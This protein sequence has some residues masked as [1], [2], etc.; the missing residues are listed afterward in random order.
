MG[1]PL[2]GRYAS[3]KLGS[4]LVANGRRWT[5]DIRLDEIDVSVFGTTWKKS[6]TG[7]QS[8]TATLEA[9]YDPADTQQ[10][11]MKAAA[12]GATKITDIRFY[13]DST[14]YWTPD[15]TADSSAGCYISGLPITHEHA[16]VASVTYNF[17]GYGEI[18]LF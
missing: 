6:M 7:M 13:I 4:D 8:W 14:S 3:V 17:V 5:L 2:R 9:L 10:A 12:I 11:A 1:D 15:V 18:D 16:G